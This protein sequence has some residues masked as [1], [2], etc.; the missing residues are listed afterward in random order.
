[1]FKLNLMELVMD[2]N[3]AKKFKIFSHDYRIN[4]WLYGLEIFYPETIFLLKMDHFEGILNR[5][6]IDRNVNDH[7]NSCNL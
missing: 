2:D 7:S 4:Y 1:M 6:K 3:I 5:I